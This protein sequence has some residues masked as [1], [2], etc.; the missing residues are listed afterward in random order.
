M[1]PHSCHFVSILRRMSVAPAPSF[2]ADP[3]LGEHALRLCQQLLRIDT[4]NPPGNERAAIDLLA[5]ELAAAGLS[6]VIHEAAPGRANLV[7][8]HKGSGARPPLLL[9]AHL[10]VVEADASR[11]SHP[12]FAGEIADGCLWGRGALDMKNMAAMTTALMCR[13]ARERTPLSRDVIFAGVADEEAGCDH[14]SAWLCANHP[15]L[16]RAEYALGEVGGFSMYLGK[17]TLYPVQVAEK[18]ICWL[19]A[20]VRGEPG[21]GS[22]PRED[23]AILRLS[24]ALARLA[25]TRLPVHVTDTMQEFLA[26]ALHRAP[27]PLR[28]LAGRALSPRLVPYLLRALPDKGLAR[29]LGAMLS[30]TASPTVLRAGSKI[31]VIPGLAEVEIDG[32]TLPGQTDADFMAELSAILGPDVELEVIRSAPP[33]VTE[34]GRSPGASPMFDTIVEV[35]GRREP[36]ATVVPYLMPG[37]TDGK[38]F[39]KLG[40]KWY[41]FSPVKLPRGMKFGELFHGT[42]ERVPIDGLKW[43]AEV[44]AEVVA[45]FCA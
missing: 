11:W 43:G 19:R 3:S 24:A 41:G 38:H 8:R 20:R 25:Q 33:L 16:V 40:A 35:L 23:S 27:R 32:R 1:N 28:A 30:N 10:D 14:G 2:T 5:G 29:S 37:Y 6:P 12:P 42:D 34:P 18:G 7:V 44:L 9:A 15:E 36:D 4:T 13:L 39:S 17:A 22:M 45:R 21:H 31:N 26:A